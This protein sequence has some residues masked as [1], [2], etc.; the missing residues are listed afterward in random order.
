ME[1]SEEAETLARAYVNYL[2]RT[3]KAG[4]LMDAYS[5]HNQS[6]HYVY[7]IVQ[8]VA[9]E[10]TTISAQDFARNLMEDWSK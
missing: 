2:V 6:C 9:E 10:G 8:A 1:S 7:S 5:D 4:D 3:G